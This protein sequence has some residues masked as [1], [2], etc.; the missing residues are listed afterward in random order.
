MYSVLNIVEGNIHSDVVMCGVRE[1]Q[2]RQLDTQIG[3]RREEGGIEMYTELSIVS[4]IRHSDV[5]MYTELGIVSRIRH[6]D[7]RQEGGGRN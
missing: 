1:V 2:Q 7:R 6:S 3:G 5:E 4:R